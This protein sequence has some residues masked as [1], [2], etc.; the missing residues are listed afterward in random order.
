[1]HRFFPDKIYMLQSPGKAYIGLCKHNKPYVV[2][3]VNRDTAKRVMKN[4]SDV[5][6]MYDSNVESISL[7]KMFITKSACPKQC[8]V[9]EIDMDSFMDM[10]LK[11]N[12]GVVLGCEIIKDTCDEI[13]LSSIVVDPFY[14][15]EAYRA[16]I[17]I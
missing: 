9:K 5:A 11:K 1:M 7:G 15:I 16:S 4:I 2:G 6:V 8:V 14:D 3:F 10:P 12:V 17:T 13:R